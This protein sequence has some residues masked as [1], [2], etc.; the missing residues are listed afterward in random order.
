MNPRPHAAKEL[1]PL[2]DGHLPAAAI[3]VNGNSIDQFHDQVRG[4]VIVGAPVNQACDVRMIQLCQDL[5]F[6]AKAPQ[7]ELAADATADQLDGHLELV[8]SV[9]APR[10]IHGPHAT[11]AQQSGQAVSSK[12]AADIRLARGLNG[13]VAKP[14]S[15]IVQGA[16]MGRIGKQ[17]RQNFCV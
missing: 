8:R 11:L 2:A 6:V 5:A 1:E 7:E 17:E 4:A 3:G 16:G 12:A 9:I 15:R 13:V 10:T 14:Q